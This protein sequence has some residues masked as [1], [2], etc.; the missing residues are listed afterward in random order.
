MKDYLSAA[1]STVAGI[2]IITLGA[3]AFWVVAVAWWV[4]AGRKEA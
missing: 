1:G 4:K 2:G 3:C